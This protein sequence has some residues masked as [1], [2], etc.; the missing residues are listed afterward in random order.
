METFIYEIILSFSFILIGIFLKNILNRFYDGSKLLAFSAYIKP[1]QIILISVGVIILVSGVLGLIYPTITPTLDIIKMVA[2]TLLAL[3][4]IVVW[5][6]STRGLKIGYIPIVL[7]ILFVGISAFTLFKTFSSLNTDKIL[8]DKERIVING[9]YGLTIP[10]STVSNIKMEEKLPK[11]SYRSNG[12]AFK[13]V[14]KGYFYLKDGASCFLSINNIESLPIIEIQRKNDIPVYINCPTSI[15]S[16]SLYLKL[17]SIF[18]K[19]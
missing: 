6:L 8:I 2:I 5:I 7:F 12:I 1:A 16:S 14:R 15:E 9:D 18:N 3:A 13:N 11:I 17:D 19:Y 4:M 10:F